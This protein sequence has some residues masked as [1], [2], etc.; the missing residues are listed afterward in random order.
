MLRRLTSLGI[1][2]FGAGLLLAACFDIQRL[3]EGGLAVAAAG[4]AG[5]ASGGMATDAGADGQAGSPLDIGGA[6]SGRGGA[7][8]TGG[9]SS[10]GGTNGAGGSA[11][12]G[13]VGAGGAVAR[14]GASAGVDWL[15]LE[16]DTAPRSLAPND[17]LGINGAFYVVHDSCARVSWDAATRCVSGELCDIGPQY[18]N[19]G[20]AVVFDFNT[21]GPEGSP[22]NTKLPWKYEDIG[23]KALA[24]EVSGVAPSLQ[25][26][27]LNM[28]PGWNGQCDSVTCEIEGPP[29]GSSG[30]AKQGQLS[31]DGMRKDDWGGSGTNYVFDP[32]LVHAVQF[33]LPA[34]LAGAQSFDFCI[35]RFGVVR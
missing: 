17:A 7:S 21:T 4:A 35:E 9:A 1:P 15:T 33:K 6:P 30:I 19:W 5:D 18:L 25:L 31:F 34:L 10:R 20:I 26:W 16:G 14:G 13:G 12:N 11:T 32:A 28:D 2:F 29:D 27:V 3:P 8:T 22:P 24:W 23:A